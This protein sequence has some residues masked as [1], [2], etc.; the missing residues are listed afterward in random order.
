MSCAVGLASGSLRGTGYPDGNQPV[1]CLIWHRNRLMSHSVVTSP[2]LPKKKSAARRQRPSQ[3]RR[4]L[5]QQPRSPTHLS[6]YP[7][8]CIM[9]SAS[10]SSSYQVRP[11]ASPMPRPQS[12]QVNNQTKVIDSE[13]G[14][15]LCIAD[16]RGRL[17]NI[18]DMVREAGA[19]A[20]IHTG[21]FGFLGATL[22]FNLN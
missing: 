3:R 8:T 5:K 22:T 11:G 2:I 7:C 18:N 19:K 4:R 9:Q 20:V 14:R 1:R 12:Q 16:I 13:H 17:S 21:D 15:I 10:R 6:I